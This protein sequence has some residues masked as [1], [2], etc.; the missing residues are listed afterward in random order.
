MT[1][2]FSHQFWT[3]RQDSLVDRALP[4]HFA[5]LVP[6]QDEE[7]TE[8][9][10]PSLPD[11]PDVDFDDPA[12]F[13]SLVEELSAWTGGPAENY[14]DDSMHPFGQQCGIVIPEMYEE[15]YAYP[16]VL[17]LHTPGADESELFDVMP[18]ISPRN[19]CG[20]SIRANA[21]AKDGGYKWSHNAAD[22]S[23]L[24]FEI[25]ETVC[26][27]RRRW[28]IHS[29]RVYIAGFGAAGTMALR[30]ML[31][32]PEWFGG[33]VSLCGRFPL[34]APKTERFREFEGKRVL[35]LGTDADADVPPSEIQTTTRL[36]DSAGFTV[37]S[38]IESGG[39]E[40]TQTM[41]RSVDQFVMDGLCA[42]A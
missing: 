1:Q 31:T 4:P 10:T 34:P 19:S 23:A 17:W 36:L 2:R 30:L 42:Y 18:Q 20:L 9:V 24:L 21:P 11:V 35:V 33:A 14:L 26:E 25:R 22:V 3:H 12:S 15:R 28:H 40:L 38:R 7:F 37:S 32:Q 8:G 27:M 5:D 39:H 41:L 6:E 29:E 16:L 13:A